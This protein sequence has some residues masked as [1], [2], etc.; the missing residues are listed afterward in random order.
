MKK[1]DFRLLYLTAE[2]WPTFRVDVNVL[3]GKEL[4]KLSIFS[5]LVT[6]KSNHSDNT[7]NWGGGELILCD[8][9]DGPIK[10]Y[11]SMLLHGIRYLFCVSPHNYDAIQVRDMPVLAAIGLFASRLKGLDFYY[12]MS[13]PIPE[14]QIELARERGL[15]AGVIKYLFPWFRGRIGKFLLYKI[16]FPNADHVFVQSNRMKS[17]MVARGIDPMR[18]TAVPMGVDLQG[19]DIETKPLPDE[20]RLV[21]RKVLIYLGTLD[22]PRRIETLFEMLALIKVQMPSV[23]LLLVGDTEDALH[24]DWLKMKAQESGVADDVVWTGWLPVSEGWRYVKAAAL[25]LSPIPRGPLLDCGSPTK[26]PEYLALGIP[27]VCNDNPDQEAIIR[28]SGAGVCVSYSAD[29]FAAAVMGVLSWSEDRR[30]RAIASGR[31]Y[32]NK[33][34]G[35]ELLSKNVASAYRLLSE[36]VA[37]A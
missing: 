2:T 13:Y 30:E 12:W 35:Y 17:D 10:K 11:T 32:V 33:H 29:S 34:R 16:I 9:S 15:S 27:V 31:A 6:G 8:I 37:A 25:G 14:G 19:I 18:M 24:R 4:P 26:V 1:T 21:G 3:F 20:P 5:D 23:M 28:E 7:C 36:Q 22:R